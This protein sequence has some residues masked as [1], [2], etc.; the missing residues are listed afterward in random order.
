MSLKDFIFTE[1]RARL[2]SGSGLYIK[3][4]SLGGK[5][6]L[7]I[8]TTSV[9]FTSRET[10][11][12]EIKVVTSDVVGKIKGVDTLNSSETEF[13]LHRDTIEALEKVNGTEQNVLFLLSD[14]SGYRQAATITY[15]PSSAEMD[16]A[17]TGT[18]KLTPKTE[19]VYEANCL[20]LL[21]KTCSFQ[22]VIPA[23]V[24]LN[25]TTAEYTLDVVCK[26]AGAT[27]TVKSSNAEVCTATVSGNKVTIKGVAEGSTLVRL[28]SNL[29]G[30]A[31][32][33]TSILVVVPK[34]SA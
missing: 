2:G 30:Y 20:P 7:L 34:A 22:S 17:I 24:E 16:G 6:R 19:L 33:N 11:E 25:T 8:P 1:D 23:Y 9:P 14:F 32:W 21:I 5:Y 13:Y 15:T 31:P 26:F 10:G 18:L 28:T 29:D 27:V 4:D 3:D 12:V